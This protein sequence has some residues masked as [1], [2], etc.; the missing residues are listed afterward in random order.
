MI[1][2]RVSFSIIKLLT[3]LLFLFTILL[4]TPWGSRVAISLLNTIDGIRFDYK[5]G[6]LIRDIELHSFHLKL[7]SIEISIKDLAADIDFSCS[8]QKKLCLDSLTASNFSLVYANSNENTSADTSAKNNAIT[9]EQQQSKN[10]VTAD[11]ERIDDDSLF[12]M[13]FAI[14]AKTVTLTKS[15]LVINKTII[16]IEEFTAQVAIQ[17]SQFNIVKPNASQLT[18]V[19]ASNKSNKYNKAIKNGVPSDTSSYTSSNSENNTVSKVKDAANSVHEI[20]STLPEIYL[21]IA[22]NIEQ[23]FVNEIRILDQEIIVKKSKQKINSSLKNST[24]NSLKN[25]QQWPYQQNH[26]SGTWLGNDVDITNF[27]TSTTDYSIKKLALKTQLIPP[28]KINAK[29]ATQLHR[30]PFWP[31]ASNAVVKVSLAGAFDD[32]TTE[33]TSQGSVVLH[34]QGQINLT[35]HLLP[36]DLTVSADK[37]PLPLSLSQ[38]GQP[39]TLSLAV[40]G[41]LDQQ[42]IKLT[43]QLNSYGYKDAQ[44]SLIAKQQQGAITFEELTFDDSSSNSQLNLQ[45]TIDF[46]PTAT[47]WQLFAD[48]SGFTLPQVNIKPLI[49]IEETS[50]Y[51]NDSNKNI[52]KESESNPV[53][54]ILPDVIH[55]RVLGKIASKGSWSASQWSFSVNDTDVSGT[56]NDSALIIQGDIALNQS[57]YFSSGNL[58]QGNLLISYDKDQLTLQTL[59]DSNINTDSKADTDN[60][61]DSNWHVNGQLL[62]TDMN[63]WYQDINGSFNTDFTVRGKKEDPIITLNS[64][65]K[66]LSWQQFYSPLLEVAVSYQPFNHHKAQLT[67]KNDYLAVTGKSKIS[68]FNAIAINLSGDLYQ[69]QLQLD[70][71]GELAGKLSLTSQWD[72]TLNHWQST[73]EHTALTYQQEV[74]RN[75][76]TFSLNFDIDKKLLLIDNHCWQAKGLELCLPF[77]ATIGE[78]GDIT[79]ALNIDLAL[80]DELLLAEEVQ[81][82]GKISGEIKAQWSA[83][84]AI[85]AQ[86]NFSLSPGNIKVNNEFNEKQISQWHQGGLSFIANETQITSKFQL[87]DV[88]KETMIN[89]NSSVN[90][91]EDFPI[92]AQIKLNQFNIQ[93]FQAL[94]N[95]VVGLQGQLSAALSIRGSI[96]SPMVDGKIALDNG[97][98]LLS[99]NPNKFEN[100]TTE[101]QIKNNQANMIG[102]FSLK[103]SKATLNGQLAWQDNFTMDIDLNAKQLPL[104]FPPMVVM[105]I[106]PTLNFALKGQSL[107]ITGNIDVLEGNYSL[108]T[109]SEGSVKLSD[110]VVIVD[111]Q[112]K[113]IF[114]ETSGFDIETDVSVNI[115]KAFKVTGQ[116]LQSH[117]FGQ[118]QISQQKKKPLQLFGRIQSNEGTYQAYG[119]RLTIDKGELTFNGPMNNPYFNLRASR[120]IRAED[121]EVGLQITGLADAL[122]IE[123]FSTPSMSSPEKLSYLVRGRGIDSGSENSTAAAS[124][125]LGFGVT[126]SAGLFDRIEE[127]PLI[128]NIAVDTEGAGDTT[129]ATISGY[130]GKRI[131]LKYGIGVYEPINE[132]TVRMY[133]LNRFWLEIV[134]GIEQST[135]IYYSFDVD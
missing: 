100:I 49:F 34:S 98:L 40:Q 7:T 46:Q 101:I 43:S 118:L 50:G 69:Q 15:H 135:D 117:L 83:K 120:H 68:E 81:L 110:D 51:S 16:D 71:Q 26:L 89:I 80:I 72:E 58:P 1:W 115:T 48:S 44:L 112:G 64:K 70:W 88:K 122:N 30:V 95:N 109:L 39:S 65:L 11:S 126:N 113:E 102:G 131:Y 13:P 133:L 134:S 114:K 103:D 60:K 125:L 9:T 84:K 87:L 28:Y 52:N 5:A 53:E 24:K 97:E 107:A 59:S 62:I 86:A 42:T 47:H 94:I 92:N 67:V 82:Q 27:Q 8:W 66:N 99:Q 55:G 129:Q 37:L 56:I 2:R 19:I 3:L 57:G 63:R 128:N 45:G 123:L 41:D 77:D 29:L 23:L 31:E 54:T 76:K 108:E 127:I 75:K 116:G 17:A 74:W 4:T 73:I 33:I 20:F 90:F 111:Q 10:D 130:I 106:S 25:D 105:N 104:V 79:L 121:I 91:I 21:P 96:E 6:A 119:Q 35:H 132:L 32:L 61:A 14:E 12:V 124:M 38:Y 18:I 78:Y 36:F 22:L 93:P 85:S